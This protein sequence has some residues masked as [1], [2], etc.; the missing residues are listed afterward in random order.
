M[1]LT[2][3]QHNSDSMYSQIIGNPTKPNKVGFLRPQYD[4]ERQQLL[5]PVRRILGHSNSKERGKL[6]ALKKGFDF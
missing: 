6:Q 4:R 2:L 5:F 1:S 3:T